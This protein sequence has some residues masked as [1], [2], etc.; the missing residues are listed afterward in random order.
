MNIKVTA[1]R[2]SKKFYYIDFIIVSIGGESSAKIHCPYSSL[3]MHGYIHTS[4][5][6]QLH[7]ALF[8]SRETNAFVFKETKSVTMNIFRKKIFSF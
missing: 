7:F 4:I 3:G 8:E 1:F 2:E 5:G 6:L